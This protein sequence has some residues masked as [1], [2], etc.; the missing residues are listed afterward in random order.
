[1]SI[2]TDAILKKAHGSVGAP[3]LNLAHGGQNGHMPALGMIQNE[4]LYQEFISNQPYVKHNIIPLVL[5]FPKFLN[6]MD[7]DGDYWKN[8]YKAIIERHASKIDG[9]SSGLTVNYDE[10]KVGTSLTHKEIVNVVQAESAI[11]YTIK[12]KANKS[13]VKFLDMFIRYGY[14]DPMSQKPLIATLLDGN[15]AL[16][17]AINGIYTSDWF[18]GT[19]IFIEPDSLNRSAVD[20]WLTFNATFD[21][22]GDRTGGM[23]KSADLEAPEISIGI[24]GMTLNND[25]VIELGD[26]LLKSLTVL[27]KDPGKDM[28]LPVDDISAEVKATTSGYNR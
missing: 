19:I 1:M 9:L 6:Y 25:N 4:K 18:T 12:D 11:T 28:P 24:S 22:T 14:M 13:I 8:A 3:S 17:T 7:G 27:S 10:H 16:E 15:P 23:D 5:E 2:I 20:A 21:G 26:K